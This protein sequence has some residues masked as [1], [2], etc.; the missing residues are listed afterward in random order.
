VPQGAKERLKDAMADSR[1]APRTPPSLPLLRAALRVLTLAAPPLAVRAAAALFRTPPRHKTSDSERQLLAAGTP[2]RV[3]AGSAEIATWTWGEGPA[4]LL[5]HGWGSRGARLGSFVEP[6]VAAGY[7]VVAFDSPAHGESPGRLSSLP[8]FIEALL[9]VARSR[10]PIHGVVAHSMGGAAAALAIT[11]GLEAERAV[12]L[13]PAANPGAYT[14]VFAQALG[15]PPHIREKMERR[16]EKQFGIRWEDFDVPTAVSS[17]STPLL[18]FHDREDREVAWGDGE[19][20]A[21]AWPGAEL[22]TTRGLG[23]TRIVHDA[24]IVRRAVDFL[25]RPRQRREAG[26]PA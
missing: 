2:E 4:M 1:T 8:Q 11:R 17:F 9:A 19:R 7:R 23:H 18:V 3:R 15:L 16:F 21:R 24:D 20:I 12:F 10:G 13:A 22:V 14:R 26:L 6:L 5:V 25:L